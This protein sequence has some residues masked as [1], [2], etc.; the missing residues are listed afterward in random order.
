MKRYIKFTSM[1]NIS[2]CSKSARKMYQ[3]GRGYRDDTL[4]GEGYRNPQEV[5]MYEILELGNIGAILFW[6]SQ[7]TNSFSNEEKA[8]LTNVKDCVDAKELAEYFSSE[9]EFVS[10]CRNLITKVIDGRNYCIWLC[11]SPEDVK[12]SYITPFVDNGSDWANEYT[13]DNIEEFSIPKDAII[14]DDLGQEGCLWCWK[15]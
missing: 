3:T 4:F 5:L 13:G 2:N 7:Y 10:F 12:S 15:Q 14:L 11:A 9:D 8:V 1:L 6:I